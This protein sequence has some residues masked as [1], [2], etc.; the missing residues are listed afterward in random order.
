VKI[1]DYK[2]GNRSL[3]PQEILEGDQLQLPLY[4]EQKVSE[5]ERKSGK[6]VVPA[7]M[8]YY[9]IDDP[10]IGEEG[11]L[12]P[13]ALEKKLRE[14]MRPSGMISEREDVLTLL[15]AELGAAAGS[16]TSD[17][18]RVDR[19]KEGGLKSGSQTVSPEVMDAV[20][21]YS[22]LEAQGMGREIL[23]G[24]KAIRPGNNECDYCNFRSVCGFEAGFPGY[25]RRPGGKLKAEEAVDKILDAV[26]EEGTEG[27][28]E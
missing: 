18:I 4:M 8:F 17:V 27:S 11:T 9:K 21:R 26:R 2:P 23:K 28:D 16:Y 10:E 13:E 20:L 14:E 25:G 12:D 22:V 19:K 1:L 15:D 3:D 5:L 24:C 7:A 6:P